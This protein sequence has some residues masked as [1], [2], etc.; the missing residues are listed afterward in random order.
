MPKLATS[1]VTAIEEVDSAATPKEKPTPETAATG[2]NA[3]AAAQA[4]EQPK[5]EEDEERNELFG[6]LSDDEL[7]QFTPEELAGINASDEEEEDE[8]ET[9][10][11][12]ET[13]EA[14]EATK[15]TEEQ[16]ATTEETTPTAAAQTP[17]TKVEPAA[18]ATEGGTESGA[19]SEEESDIDLVAGVPDWQLPDNAEQELQ[20]LDQKA[21]EIAEQFDAGKLNASQFHKE[22]ASVNAQKAELTKQV[23]RAEMAFQMRQTH[24]VKVVVGKFLH[25]H[26]EYAPKNPVLYNALDAEVRRL[27]MESDDPFDPR[28][29]RQAHANLEQAMGRT[30]TPPK[31]KAP[32]A[33]AAAAKPAP[34]LPPKSEKP[35]IPPT[36]ARVPSD[37]VE[38]PRGGKFARLEQLSTKD[39][40][41]YEDALAKMS[42]A[43]RDEYLAGAA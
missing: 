20:A 1:T 14:I 24:F 2:D 32:P 19:L 11:G 42:P 25:D 43:D 37:T 21:N 8:E 7:A 16:A 39:P 28:L 33:A 41:A 13:P 29:L 34:K 23:D 17:V 30:A 22:L 6:K 27:Q 35:Q 38:D 31:P 5:P 9:E 40:T 18:P 10:T 26:P 3:A 12:V 15:T 4:P 36:L